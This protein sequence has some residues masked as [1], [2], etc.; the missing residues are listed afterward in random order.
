MHIVSRRGPR[1]TRLPEDFERYVAGRRPGLVRT[2]YL[3][4]GDH[5]RAEELVQRA[6]ARTWL[7]WRRLGGPAAADAYVLHAVVHAH[8]ST[9]RRRRAGDHPR[10]HGPDRHD[11]LWAGLH[12]L[13]RPQRA[14]LVLRY[15]EDLPDA[16]IAHL[17]GVPV[18]K[19][20]SLAARGLARLDEC[21]V[22][23]PPAAPDRR[24]RQEVPR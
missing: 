19:V 24:V 15:Y 8:R 12:D 11:A 22:A 4:V 17:L 1:A 20:E 2:A 16:Q 9:W 5:A 3:L 21:G 7:A 10:A 6:L 18:A 23:D 13:P 14:T